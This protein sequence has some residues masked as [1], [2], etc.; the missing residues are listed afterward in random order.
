MPGTQIDPRLS[1]H[2]SDAGCAILLSR[3][4]VRDITD[5][6][7]WLAEANREIAAGYRRLADPTRGVGLGETMTALCEDGYERHGRSRT[8]AVFVA[9]TGSGAMESEAREL[10]GVVRL[11]IGRSQGA[12]RDVA[13]IDAMNFV[14]PRGGWPHRRYGV[15]DDQIGEI[16]RFVILEKFRRPRRGA[17]GGQVTITGLLLQ[18]VYRSCRR[19]GLRRL[20]AIMPPQ[21]ADLVTRTGAVLNNVPML[22]RQEDEHAARIFEQFSTYWRRME[23]RL[24]EVTDGQPW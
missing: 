21:V 6:P 2:P 17:E 4:E 23:P 13:P 19:S 12:P 8:F 7:E 11:V 10:A 1:V 3:A 18:A 22:L 15:R 24:Y 16:G 14:S 9:G 5:H 20:Y